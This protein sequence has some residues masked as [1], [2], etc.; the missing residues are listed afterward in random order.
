MLFALVV[1]ARDLIYKKKEKEKKVGQHCGDF[2]I[3]KDSHALL[4]LT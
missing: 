2:I 4:P 3:I 1:Y